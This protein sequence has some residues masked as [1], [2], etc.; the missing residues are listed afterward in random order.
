MAA[1]GRCACGA[2][3]YEVVG[4]PL[5]THACH[6]RDCQRT[7]GSAFI[8][9][10]ILVEDDLKLE[11]ET[12]MVSLPTG[13]GAGSEIHACT[14]CADYIWVRY[15]YHQVPVVA[16]RTGT[17]DDPSAYPPEAH[18][19]VGSKQPW[20]TLGDGKPQFQEAFARENGWPAAS[21]ARYDVLPKKS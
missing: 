19:F 14:T 9:H 15:L 10:S 17:L 13:S 16:L 21:V 12:R 1:T 5:F 4:T 2:V 7:T 20:L 18:I 11:G 6:C 3:T 8:V